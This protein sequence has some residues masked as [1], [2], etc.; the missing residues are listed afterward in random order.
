MRNLFIFIS[1]YSAFFLFLIF[2]VSS[3]VILVKYNSFQKASFINS[4]SELTGIIYERVDEI[5]RYLNLGQTNTKLAEENARLRSQL[6]SSFY[7]TKSVDSTVTDTTYKQQY[8][9][10]QAQVINNSISRS[11]N[12]LTL[13]RGSDQG[14]AK[15]MGVIC[16][17]GV[18]GKVVN[19][20]QHFSTVQSL[21]H[22]DFRVS[23]LLITSKA[24]GSVKWGDDLNPYN[25]ILSDVP[26]I[27][28]PKVGEQVVTS[29]YSLFP[30]G[31]SVGKIS[32]IGVK[33]GTNF[34]NF[35]I[36]LSTDFARLQQVYVVKNKLQQEQ[37]T[38]ESQ[39]KKDDE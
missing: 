25:A 20:T 37:Q 11:N 39:Q 32:K 9:Y 12:Y 3:L 19:V 27:A 36:R 23:G 31:I 26:N 30:M 8:T 10:I 2:E 28:K 14:I 29:E 21:L 33:G 1:R 7:H 17:T 15:G 16:P 6:K 34:V 5:T 13:N 18:V 4:S 22:K 35:E 24:F 38:L